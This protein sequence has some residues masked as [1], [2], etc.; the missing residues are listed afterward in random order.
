MGLDPHL[1]GSGNDEVLTFSLTNTFSTIQSLKDELAAIRSSLDQ[2]P[3]KRPKLPP[4]HAN[5]NPSMMKMI[6]HFA[7]EIDQTQHAEPN[8]HLNEDATFSEDENF[9]HTF[10]NSTLEGEH[11]SYLPPP[12]AIEEDNHQMI[13][14]IKGFYN[15]IHNEIAN[16]KTILKDDDDS[17]GN[18]RRRR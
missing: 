11:S 4:S 8:S 14:G 5:S 1:R 17:A 2:D 18:E 3:A 12:E 15:K 7:R 13:R 10:R 16:L 6:H 9:V